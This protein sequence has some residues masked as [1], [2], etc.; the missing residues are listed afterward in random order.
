MNAVQEAGVRTFAPNV[1]SPRLMVLRL[2]GHNWLVVFRRVSAGA[3][4]PPPAAYGKSFG[5]GEHCRWPRGPDPS[6][7][8]WCRAAGSSSHKQSALRAERVRHVLVFRPRVEQLGRA[9]FS[10]HRACFCRQGI[11]SPEGERLMS[12]RL[13]AIQHR[14][15]DSMD[16]CTL[17]DIAI[18]GSMCHQSAH[19]SLKVMTK[20]GTRHPLFQ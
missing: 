8:R 5:V 7:T 3:H 16:A 15:D 14:I 19:Y 12:G 9:L 2:H 20:E 11:D 13:Q 17:R 18:S 6:H 1:R 10:L 4:S